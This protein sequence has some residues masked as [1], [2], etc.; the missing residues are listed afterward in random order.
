MWWAINYLGNSRSWT[1]LYTHA[2]TTAEDH[3]TMAWSHHKPTRHGI[4]RVIR[5]K[6]VLCGYR[7]VWDTP[8]LNE[9]V[10]PGDTYWHT[11]HIHY[12]RSD[13][14]VWYYLFAPDGPYGLEI[15][16]PLIHIPPP[17]V[18]LWATKVYVG[19][20]LKGL[21]YTDTFTGPGGADPVW[22]TRNLGLDSLKIWQLEPDPLGPAIRF[23]CIAGDPDDRKVY[24][25]EPPLAEE[26][27]PI[28]THAEAVALTGSTDGELCWVTTNTLFPGYIYVLFNS[29]ITDNGTWCLRSIDYGLNWT[30]HQIYA[31]IQN[32]RAGNLS[33]GL[34]Q[35]DSPHDPGTVLYAALCTHVSAP[36]TLWLSLDHGQTWQARDYKGVG[37]QVPR[38]LVDPTDQSTVYLGAW[39]NAPH[40]HELFRS[41][42]H[43]A[44]LLEVDGPLHIG[45]LV[46]TFPGVLWINPSDQYTMIVLQNDHLYTTEDYATTWLDHEEIAHP[47]TRLSLLW[48]QPAHLYLGQDTPGT[49]PPFTDATHV[50]LVSQTWGLAMQGKAGANA[51]AIDGMGDSIPY[52]CG[53]ISLQGIMPFPLE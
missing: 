17:E 1:C 53:G 46:A 29:A 49:F 44:N 35:G 28:L 36:A 25:R 38:C 32:Y 52:N 14:H 13:Q 15:Q 39:L 50:I 31:G 34:A 6:D 43:G 42:Q 8:I 4:W 19:T 12:L 26:W 7:Y 2:G 20:Q 3:L 27:F 23:Y 22:H 21:F 30:A 41:E 5:G 9:Q 45:P 11:F 37:I 33:V 18:H 47:A 48:G 24:K 40:P 51:W 16:G 10:E